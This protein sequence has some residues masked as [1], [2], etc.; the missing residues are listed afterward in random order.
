MKQQRIL[1]DWTF[2]PGL[3][4]RFHAPEKRR[5]DLPHDLQL[6]V[7][8][9]PEATAAS[10]FYPGCAGV[11][12]KLLDIP[13]Q[14]AGQRVL[15]VFDGVYMQAA[16][17]LNGSQLALHPYGYSPFVVDL[18]R[19]VR[20]G[21]RNRLEV[22]ADATAAPN[23]RWYPGAGIYR[24][25]KLVHGPLVRIAYQGLSLTT[26]SID[27]DTATLTAAVQVEND[28]ITPFQG[29]VEVTLTGPDGD[30]TSARTSVWAEPGESALARLRFVVRQPRLWTAETPDLYDASALLT[31]FATGEALDSDQ[32]RVGIRTVQVDP[33]HGLRINGRTVKLKGGCVHHTTGPLGA[34][35]FDSQ[36]RRVLQVH[37]DAGYNALRTAHNPPSARFLDLCDEY[38]LYVI[39]E[40]FDGWHVQKTPQGY[41]QAFD[42]W[43]ERDVESFIRR[44]RNH[45][46]VIFWSIGNEVFER[47]GTGGGYR[48]SQQLAE[49]VRSLDSTRP[50]MMALC[51][52]WN[53]LDDQDAAEAAKRMGTAAAGQ[54][55]DFSYLNEI[56]ASRTESMA[57]PLDVVGYNYMEERYVPDHQLFPQRVICGTESFPMEIDRVWALV[58]QCPYVIGDF[59]WTSAEYIGEAGIGAVEYADPDSGAEMT[60]HGAGRPYPWKLAYD[61]DWD[62]LNQ[63]R[64]QLAYRKI[65][66]GGSDTYIAVRPPRNY[67]KKELLSRWAWPEVWNSWTWP[68][69]EGRLVA[70]DVYTP[71][72]TVE[73][74]QD[75]K[76]LGREKAERFTARFTTVYQPGRLEAVSYLAGVEIS[77]DVVETAGEPAALRL[78]PETAAA[79]A[80]GEELLFVLVE[81]VDSQG[82]RVPGVCRSL[83]AGVEGAASLQCFA[84]ANPITDEDTHS[85]TIRSFDGRAMAVLR[86]G[87]E[88]GKATLTVSCEGLP[89]VS[90]TLDIL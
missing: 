88:P 9:T 44:D 73:L 84:S 86:T 24:E 17:S 56:W 39:D 71:G 68:G 90:Q 30:V 25:V 4:D 29:H 42:D 53:G 19:R 62:F 61:G 63:P 27:G 74:F 12:E 6:E 83:T 51:S 78:R 40:A 47:A 28:T 49:K 50:V 79:A 81:F 70:I 65:V 76:S 46:S 87:R 43:W 57:S 33:I 41:H 1:Q 35:D 69:D 54:N 82:R 7:P 18:T 22:V 80:G 77:R 52:L 3:P 13:A 14:W 26:E 58:E 48:L 37:K 38:G 64:P 20:F 55:A 75:G 34:A 59:T 21:E 85:G 60:D 45:P 31:D 5:L 66:W 11:Y 23:C 32:A 36:T 67:G 16:V 2:Y 10:G 72:D 89:P 15:A 8:Q